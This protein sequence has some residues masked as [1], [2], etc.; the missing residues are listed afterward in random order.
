M[1][2]EEATS[3]PSAVVI[4]KSSEMTFFEAAEICFCHLASHRTHS[5]VESIKTEGA[6]LCRL[7]PP[8]E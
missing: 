8:R 2:H 6:S 3:A 7:S 5:A 1:I 4:L